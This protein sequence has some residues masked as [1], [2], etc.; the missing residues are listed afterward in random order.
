MLAYCLQKHKKAVVIGERTPGAANPSSDFKV[1]KL[2][3]MT[4]ATGAGKH[5]VTG[6]DWEGTGVVPD[7]PARPHEILEVTFKEARKAI[8]AG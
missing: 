3:T 8:R 7:I 2:F 6:K 4:I 1:N 5:P